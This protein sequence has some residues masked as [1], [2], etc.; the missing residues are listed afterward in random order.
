MTF[1]PACDQVLELL[2]RP[3]PEALAAHAHGCAHCTA[4]LAAYQAAEAASV[5]S[6]PELA[7]PRI[8]AAALSELAKQP[9]VRPWWQGALALAGFNAAVAG[10]AALLLGVQ[11]RASGF[12]VA[13]VACVLLAS[14]AG[15]ALLA[16]A[17]GRRPL[18]FTLLGGMA[19]SGV[20]LL[21]G[22][23]GFEPGRGFLESGLKCLV[24]EVL[25]SVLPLATGLFLL[26]RTAPSA[27][28]AAVLGAACGVV[29]LLALHLHC[30]NGTVGHL[31]PFH[32]LPWLGL[33][34]GAVAVRA[35]LP[36]RSYAP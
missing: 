16:L 13:A 22:A 33:A 12:A 20:A 1:T 36:T 11:N 8:R 28:R 23:S 9:T 14:M 10:V 2:G 32:V 6:T 24:S 18:A 19:V 30:P 4:T 5:G 29:G 21:F 25:L 26:T 35:L 27:L 17:P 34:V 3:L 15:S 7:L 31:V